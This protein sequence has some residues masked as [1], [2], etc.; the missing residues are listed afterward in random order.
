MYINKKYGADVTIRYEWTWELSNRRKY[1]NT[2]WVNWFIIIQ[3]WVDNL[4]HPTAVNIGVLGTK[5][6]EL[7]PIDSSTL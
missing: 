7:Q 5:P 1:V 4:Y 3:C 2:K 6:V